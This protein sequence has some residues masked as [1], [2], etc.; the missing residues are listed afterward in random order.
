MMATGDRSEYGWC[1]L[2]PITRKVGGPECWVRQKGTLNDRSSVGKPDVFG[3]YSGFPYRFVVAVME[4][5]WTGNWNGLTTDK[6][7]LGGR[8]RQSPVRRPA[9]YPVSKP[10]ENQNRATFAMGLVGCIL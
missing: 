4:E 3:G 10:K 8:T 6:T 5:I 1:A 7:G 9:S 2:V